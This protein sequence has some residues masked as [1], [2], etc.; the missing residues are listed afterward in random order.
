MHNIRVQT[1]TVLA[2]NLVNYINFLIKMN[3]N[4][5]AYN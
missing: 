4:K 2:N 1:R 3:T 5:N